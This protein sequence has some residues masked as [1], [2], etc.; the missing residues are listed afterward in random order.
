MAKSTTSSKSTPAP[1]VAKSNKSTP[2]SAP[3]PVA[4]APAP[5]ATA[6]APVA[7]KA[8]KGKKAT[9][10]AP[11][12][13]APV[14]TAPVSAPSPVQAQASAPVKATK[15]KKASASV[16]ASASASVSVSAS[17]PV[18][19]PVSAPVTTSV[20]AQVPAKRTRAVKGKGAGK[21]KAVKKVRKAVV[22]AT[23]APVT[24]EVGGKT[25]YFKLKDEVTQ[26]EEGAGDTHGRYS[27]FKQ[28]ANKAFTSLLKKMLES[29][30]SIVGKEY[31]FTIVEC[32]RGRRGRKNKEYHYTGVRQELPKPVEVK[33]VQTD[34][35]TGVVSDKVIAY[36][37]KNVVK[38]TPKVKAQ[39]A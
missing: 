11:V 27:G 16:D 38:K 39:N 2:A 33:K 7:A 22:K 4:S 21:G 37:Y 9:A 5:V 25:R 3:A 34:K 20:D 8:S 29:E 1:K 12:A 19:A 23:P 17:V 32:T 6:P 13:T 26:E 36:K 35:K 24:E 14:A 18:S 15:A 28:A 10:T 31:K 30:A